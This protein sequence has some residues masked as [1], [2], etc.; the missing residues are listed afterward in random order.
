MSRAYV[1]KNDLNLV[2]TVD[3]NDGRFMHVL[4]IDLF[5]VFLSFYR[6]MTRPMKP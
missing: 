5:C 1:F 2:G 6:V 4:G 3:G